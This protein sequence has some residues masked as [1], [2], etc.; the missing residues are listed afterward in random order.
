MFFETSAL[1]NENI[2]ESFDQCAR[3]ILNKIESGSIDPFRTYS[4][5]QCN[6]SLA[7]H[8]NENLANNMLQKSS[9]NCAL[10]QT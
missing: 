2:T 10:C 6:R 1:N 7:A 9:R 4:G 5:I 3:I 8:Q